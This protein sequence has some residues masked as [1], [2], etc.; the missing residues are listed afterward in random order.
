[1]V[2]GDEVEADIPGIFGGLPADAPKNRLGLAQWL[3]SPDNPLTARVTVN[4]FW[5]QLFGFGII[6]TME[7][8][9]SQGS[10]PSNVELLDWLAVQFMDEYQWSVKRLLKEIVMSAAYQQNSN[11]TPEKIEM[12]PQ[13][14]LL[15]RGPR[16][17]LS[18]E[19]IRDQILSVSGLIN[20]ELYGPSI[21]PPRP[22]VFASGW[23]SWMVDEGDAQYRRS[24]YIFTKRTSPY[25]MLTTFDATPRNVCTSRRI[26]TNTPLQALTLLNDSTFYM[27]AEQLG[28]YM[29]DSNP[30]NVNECIS[31]GYKRVMFHRPDEVTTQ[32]LGKLYQ[33]AINHY[34]EN[35]LV[36]NISLKEPNNQREK[37]FSLVANVM[38]NLDEFMTKN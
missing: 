19:Q 34:N 14:R 2:L 28:K 36:R 25:P 23:G 13:N 24:L 4:R 3:I 33:E 27:A 18:V 32:A 12:D 10:P 38:L 35:K 15:S 6:E 5:E 7:E 16:V 17:R 31:N 29:A 21:K 1:M 22:D 9:G 8:F 26:R 30:N 11:A 20:L 37:A